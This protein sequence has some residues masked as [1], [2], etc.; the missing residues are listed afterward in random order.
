M[1]W[2]PIQLKNVLHQGYE[3]LD[4]N[5]LANKMQE[6]EKIKPHLLYLENLMNK[7]HNYLSNPTE[8]QFI[9]GKV[10]PYEA[11]LEIQNMPSEREKRLREYDPKKPYDNLPRY[12]SDI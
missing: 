4:S 6:V 7:L 11:L 8:Q 9:D 5:I 3:V 12:I 10:D 1:I 2:G